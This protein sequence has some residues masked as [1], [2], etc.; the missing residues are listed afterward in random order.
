MSQHLVI[1]FNRHP[2][3]R[4]HS[5]HARP[6][7]SASRRDAVDA[8]TTVDQC[9]LDHNRLLLLLLRMMPSSHRPTRLDKTVLSH[10]VGVGADGI[11]WILDDSRLS[12]TENLKR[13]LILKRTVRRPRTAA[14]T[15]PADYSCVA[16]GI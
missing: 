1:H 4:S 16:T 6:S 8:L 3:L 5:R 7:L 10:R 9:P 12:P 13:V 15:P 14:A 11:N 2:S